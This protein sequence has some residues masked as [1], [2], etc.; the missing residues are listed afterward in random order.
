[1]EPIEENDLNLE[2]KL[3]KENVGGLG[4]ENNK[5]YSFKIEKE[6]VLEKSGAEKDDAYSQIISKLNDDSV[7]TDVDNLVSDDA[8]NA[9]EKVDADSQV[10]HLVDIAMAKGVVYAV[11]VARHMEDNYVLDTFHDKL[12]ADELHDAL[13]EKG[14][15][16]NV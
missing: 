13:V 14:L 3:K 9:F 5:E 15:L 6:A 1:M 10:Q 8:R 11:K 2:N 4:F 16:K 12:M 7:D